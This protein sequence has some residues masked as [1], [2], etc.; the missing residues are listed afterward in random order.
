MWFQSPPLSIKLASLRGHVNSNPNTEVW[1]CFSLAFH[2]WKAWTIGL[3]GNCPAPKRSWGF[4]GESA[5]SSSLCFFL[6]PERICGVDFGSGDCT[7][8]RCVATPISSTTSSAG[9]GFAL[10][11]SNPCG[12]GAQSQI[13]I[14]EVPYDIGF[15]CNVCT[16]S[17]TPQTYNIPRSIGLNQMC[18]LRTINK[19]QGCFN[20]YLGHLRVLSIHSQF[21]NPREFV[22]SQIINS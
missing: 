5:G 10:C 13:T 7:G 3:F 9:G 15:S 11:D 6:G 2:H 18:F 17:Y 19:N 21:P 16:S 8:E 14:R 20:W 12:H 1:F 22:G 4:K